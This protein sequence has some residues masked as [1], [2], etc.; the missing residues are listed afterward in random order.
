MKPAIEAQDAAKLGELAI[1]APQRPQRWLL[2]EYM[3][4]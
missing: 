1:D 2:G 4:W 3:R